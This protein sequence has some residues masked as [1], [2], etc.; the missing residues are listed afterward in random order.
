MR[1]LNFLKTFFTFLK[2]FSTF[3]LHIFGFYD[4]LKFY[5]VLAIVQGVF[6]FFLQSLKFLPLVVPKCCSFEGSCSGE[7][8]GRCVRP[9]LLLH[10]NRGCRGARRA[11]QSCCHAFTHYVVL[12]YGVLKLLYFNILY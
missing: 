7:R 8:G 1:F 5:F 12:Y 4:F 10:G 6:V 11:D 2:H 3:F 9:P